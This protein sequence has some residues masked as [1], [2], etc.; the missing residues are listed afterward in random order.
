MYCM[1]EGVRGG[2]Q[3]AK[4]YAVVVYAWVCTDMEDNTL[5]ADD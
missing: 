1:E 2:S 4:I 3:N 5:R